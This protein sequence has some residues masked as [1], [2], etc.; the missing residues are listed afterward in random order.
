MDYNT[1]R[2]PLALPEYGRNIQKMVDYAKT[3]EDRD[4]RNRFVHALIDIMGSMNPHLRDINDFK[5][6]LW[7]HVAIMA[8]F[9]LD[10]DSPYPIPK[11]ETFQEKPR[12]LAYNDN[13]IK[14]KYYGKTLQKLIE[15]VADLDDSKTKE[16]LIKVIMNHMKKVY[17]MWNK[18]TVDDRVIFKDISVLSNGKLHIDANLKLTNS[19]EILSKTRKKRNSRTNSRK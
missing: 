3:I 2:K 15:K 16:S 18:E 5:H 11:P 8:N 19:R 10:I 4:A 9:D 17:L 1:S 13:N 12:T 7:D 6:K 14:Y